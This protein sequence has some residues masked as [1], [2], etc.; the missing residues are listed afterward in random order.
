MRPTGAPILMTNKAT[1]T[2]ETIY[3]QADK[4]LACPKCGELRQVEVTQYLR[5][6]EAFCKTCAHAWQLG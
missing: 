4:E 2:P 1:P 6:I 3:A 5:R